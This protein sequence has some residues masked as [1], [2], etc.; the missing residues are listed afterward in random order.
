MLSQD[1]AMEKDMEGTKLLESL[2]KQ[3]HGYQRLRI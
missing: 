2:I 3:E 1:T